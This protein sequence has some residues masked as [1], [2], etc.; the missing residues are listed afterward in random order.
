M[1]QA[2]YWIAAHLLCLVPPLRLADCA[3]Q[4]WL[5]IRVPALG[6]EE[7]MET[8]KPAELQ[9]RSAQTVGHRSQISP[10]IFLADVIRVRTHQKF[11]L[12]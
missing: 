1:Q 12:S 3:C 5:S 4:P 2:V 9:G 6:G 10:V 8:Q 7:V 11:F